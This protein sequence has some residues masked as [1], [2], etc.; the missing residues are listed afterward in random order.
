[1]INYKTQLENLKKG[2][3]EDKLVK[4]SINYLKKINKDIPAWWCLNKKYIKE[5]LIMVAYEKE[6][7]I[8]TQIIDDLK[9]EWQKW[10]KIMIKK[11]GKKN[12]NKY[13]EFDRIMGKIDLI[14]EITGMSSEELKEVLK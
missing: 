12:A 10:D 14:S 2:C 11:S 9:K 4:K 1:V 7:E 8:K 13:G 6:L 5:A 3:K